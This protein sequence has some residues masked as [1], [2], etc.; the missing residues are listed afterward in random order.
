MGN[1]TM[2]TAQGEETE[3]DGRLARIEADLRE[4][5]EIERSLPADHVAAA[6][7]LWETPRTYYAVDEEY[8]D[9]G[10]CIV[11]EVVVGFALF[12]E[13]AFNVG[14]MRPRE[15]VVENCPKA[16]DAWERRDLSSAR[17]VARRRL[18]LDAIHYPAHVLDQAGRHGE[19]DFAALI[20]DMFDKLNRLQA[21][22]L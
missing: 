7:Q 14:C 8:G 11:G 21:D 4:L 10:P 9:L 16:L 12:D 1:E 2:E 13:G 17:E 3:Q 18:I 19:V 15:W 5:D 22:R 20:G 6:W